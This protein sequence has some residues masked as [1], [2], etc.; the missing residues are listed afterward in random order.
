MLTEKDKKKIID[1][2]KPGADVF[3]EQ[4]IVNDPKDNPFKNVS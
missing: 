2:F 1:D 4:E 3:V